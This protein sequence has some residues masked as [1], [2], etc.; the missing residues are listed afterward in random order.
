MLVQTQQGPRSKEPRGWWMK[1][2]REATCSKTNGC[3]TLQTYCQ[4]VSTCIVQPNFLYLCTLKPHNKIHWIEI[5]IESIDHK[6]NRLTLFL[7]QK[8]SST[9]WRREALSTPHPS[10]PNFLHNWATKNWKTV[11]ESSHKINWGHLSARNVIQS[12]KTVSKKWTFCLYQCAWLK[13]Y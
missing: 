1:V 11:L 5:Y 2:T 10:P 12:T 9:S 8:F 6:K 3:T 4:D 7:T 13:F